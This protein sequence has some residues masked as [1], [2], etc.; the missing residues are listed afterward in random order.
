MDFIEP[1]FNWNDLSNNS[2]QSL[3]FMCQQKQLI[4][5]SNKKTDYI[6]ALQEFLSKPFLNNKKQQFSKENSREESPIITFIK[7][8][9]IINNNIIEK[10]VTSPNVQFKKE[11]IISK[12]NYLILKIQNF[13]QKYIIKHNKITL[14]ISIILFLISLIFFIKNF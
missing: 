8:K 6:L 13:I 5:N 2:L 9:S 11:I 14:Y 1:E 10:R 3:K 12:N 7:P 4:I